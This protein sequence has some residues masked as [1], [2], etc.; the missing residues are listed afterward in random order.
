MQSAVVVV[1]YGV[2]E[3]HP[4]V[5][6]LLLILKKMG[7]KVHFVGIWS[8]AG[9]DFLDKHQIPYHFLPYK[10]SKNYIKRAFVF[11]KCRF[12]I[13]KLLLSLKS[14]YGAL[15]LWFQECHSA[16][17]VGDRMY[18]IGKCITTFYEY[19]LNYGSRWFGFNFKRMMHSNVIVE[20]E[21]NRAF[22]TQ[23]IHGLKDTPLLL[24]NKP[25]IDVFQVQSLPRNIKEIFEK[26]SPRP[27]F[28]YQGYIAKDR[29][30]IPFILEVIAENRPNYC[31]VC[32]TNNVEIKQRLSKYSNAYVLS[33]IPAPGHLAVTAMATV[34]IAAYNG[35]GGASWY[36]NSIYCAPNKIYEYAAFGVPTL[37]NLIPGLIYSI[38]MAKAG[39]CCQVEKSSILKA[40]DELIS[41]IDYYREKAF[42]FYNETN[43]ESQVQSILS[44]AERNI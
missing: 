17:L 42:K 11:C 34:G 2:L 29:S 10:A 4:P 6:T 5:M 15:V 9:Q 30:D 7:R 8:V 3:S 43:L 25:Q 21:I 38:G 22:M 23:A 19:E 16:A 36:L 31:V 13:I 26:I 32:L 39:I 12:F 27:V 1:K 28:L 14:Q 37:G 18:K 44:R 20:C 35:E 40:A 33:S 24:V 41:K